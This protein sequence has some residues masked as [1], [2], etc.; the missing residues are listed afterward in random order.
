M[1]WLSQ[2]PFKMFYSCKT[3]QVV[4]LSHIWYGFIY[5]SFAFK[6]YFNLQ[7][8]WKIFRLTPFLKLSIYI[9]F[10]NPSIFDTM[11]LFFSI[12][13]II[14]YVKQDIYNTYRA[15]NGWNLSYFHSIHKSNTIECAVH[16]LPYTKL[17]H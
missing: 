17:I 4:C 10:A 15:M 13:R 3:K 12:R 14:N 6:M 7:L 2:S 9:F 16:S 5:V 1:W 8:I 11:L